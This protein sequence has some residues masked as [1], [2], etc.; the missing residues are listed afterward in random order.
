MITSTGQLVD[1]QLDS[2]Y[3]S[4]KA[5]PHRHCSAQLRTPRPPQDA[6]PIPQARVGAPVSQLQKET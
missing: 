6:H 3:L 4:Y 5:R 1:N 2:K